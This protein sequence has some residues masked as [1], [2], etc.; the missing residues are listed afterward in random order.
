MAKQRTSRG[1]K[2]RVLIWLVVDTSITRS[3]GMTA[4]GNLTCWAKVGM[5]EQIA[6]F[7]QR[8]GE[9]VLQGVPRTL[10]EQERYVEH[11]SLALLEQ[12]PFEFLACLEDDNYYEV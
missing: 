1:L 10:Q 9:L 2:D 12:V 8:E 4:P 5:I 11:H 6:N 3:K 7:E